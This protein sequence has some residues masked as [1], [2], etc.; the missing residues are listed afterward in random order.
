MEKKNACKQAR[1]IAEETAKPLTGMFVGNKCTPQRFSAI[2]KAKKQANELFNMEKI[3]VRKYLYTNEVF[4]YLTKI[5]KGIA[6]YKAEIPEMEL[7]FV[8]PM[9]DMG[10]ADFF[11]AMQA[12]HLF[13]WIQWKE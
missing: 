5:R 13:R 4:A 3:E 10:D 2:E 9:Q 7:S 12:K 8:I 6:Y 11:Y 1:I